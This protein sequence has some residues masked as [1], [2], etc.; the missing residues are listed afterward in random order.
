[1]RLLLNNA[2]TGD[3]LYKAGHDPCYR[4]ILVFLTC[5]AYSFY[6]DLLNLSEREATLF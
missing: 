5:N 1:M 4:S 2:V 3:N 6:F